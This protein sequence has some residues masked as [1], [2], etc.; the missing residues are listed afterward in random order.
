MWQV[1]GV[2]PHGSI[3]AQPPELNE[4]LDGYHVEGIG[5][6]FIP[7]VLNRKLVDNWIKTSDAEAFTMA[8]RSRI[9]RTWTAGSQCCTPRRRS[10]AP[11]LWAKKP[12]TA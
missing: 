10:P 7:D 2:D 5:Y 1:V 12:H 4:C 8:R 9:V 3:L 11:A 6:D